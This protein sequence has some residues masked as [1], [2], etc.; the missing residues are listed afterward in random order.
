M[1][2]SRQI[3]HDPG[4][5]GVTEATPFVELRA[6]PGCLSLERDLKEISGLEIDS[7]NSGAIGPPEGGS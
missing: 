7:R 4:D 2:A 1:D 5:D 3:L 6:N